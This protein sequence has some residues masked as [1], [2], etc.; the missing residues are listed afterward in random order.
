MQRL[1]GHHRAHGRSGE[2]GHHDG[3]VEG[4]PPQPHTPTAQSR[5]LPGQQPCRSHRDAPVHRSRRCSM[6]L[7]GSRATLERRTV[8]TRSNFPPPSTWCAVP[9]PCLRLPEMRCWVYARA[10]CLV[11][12]QLGCVVCQ[13]HRRR[14][15]YRLA[16]TNPGSSTVWGGSRAGSRVVASPGTARPRVLAGRSPPY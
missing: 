5:A 9:L 1:P 11:S 13:S 6:R 12:R 7:M 16:F 14:P 2:P 4:T 10:S 3:Q 8:S 15:A